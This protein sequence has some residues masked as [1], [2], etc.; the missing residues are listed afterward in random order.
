M[1]RALGIETFLPDEPALSLGGC[2]VSAVMAV[3]EEDVFQ[4][5]KSMKRLKVRFGRSVTC[6]TK[7]FVGV[8]VQV[9]PMQLATVYGTIAAG[10]VYHK[11]H[12]ITRIESQDG[13]ILEERHEVGT[14]RR[15]FSTP[16][17]FEEL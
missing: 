17:I 12:F 1:G 16:F 3:V 9:T 5:L 4:V 14:T 10:G 13:Q 6:I 15:S 8:E 7:G 11:P 2:E